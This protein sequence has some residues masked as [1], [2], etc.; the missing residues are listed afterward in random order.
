MGRDNLICSNENIGRRRKEWHY[1]DFKNVKGNGGK[2]CCTIRL[3]HGSSGRQRKIIFRKQG[4]K[5]VA[6]VIAIAVIQPIPQFVAAEAGNSITID[7]FAGSIPAATLGTAKSCA[8]T[9]AV[10]TN[11]V[12]ADTV[13]A[14][15]CS[16][17]AVAFCNTFSAGN[18]DAIAVGIAVKQFQPSIF[19]D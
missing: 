17:S 2:C 14:S 8:S 6:V 1:V 12:T 16:I 4:P 19:I 15:A 18:T 3:Q 11:P 10:D 7:T 9:K 5:S 13:C